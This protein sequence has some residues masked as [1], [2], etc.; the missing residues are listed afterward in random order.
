MNCNA[1]NP[2]LRGY[3]GHFK[4]LDI[5]ISTSVPLKESGHFTSIWGDFRIVILET[6]DVAFTGHLPSMLF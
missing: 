2:S 5:F 4:R 1:Q 6:N 3:K